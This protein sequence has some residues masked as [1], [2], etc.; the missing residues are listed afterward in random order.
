MS[1]K[2]CLYLTIWVLTY[3][4]PLCNE[5][6]KPHPYRGTNNKERSGY[7]PRGN[8]GD[9]AGHRRAGM[10]SSGNRTRGAERK[11]GRKRQAIDE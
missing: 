6:I 2:Y 8:W 11:G 7:M 1:K 3:L 4:L 10:M 5:P 9:P